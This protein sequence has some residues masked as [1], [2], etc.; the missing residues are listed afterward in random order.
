MRFGLSNRLRHAYAYICHT[1]HRSY[2]LIAES[3]HVD[4]P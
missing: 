2:R 1:R 3:Q 4:A